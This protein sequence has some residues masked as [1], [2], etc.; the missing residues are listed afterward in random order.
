LALL[1]CSCGDNP[2]GPT[3]PTGG[4]KISCPLDLSIQAKGL[5]TTL[6]YAPPIVT[7]GTAPVSVAC[8]PSS[9]APIPVGTTKVTCIAADG[10]QRAD[11][12]TFNAVV[13]PAPMLSATR[14]VAFGDSQTEGKLGPTSYVGNPQFPDAYAAVLYDTLTKRYTAQTVDMF[15]RGL[16]GERVQ[17][18]GVARLPTVLAADAPQVLLLLEGVNDLITFGA[19]AIPTVINGLRTMVR[20]AKGRGITVFL[21]TLLPQRPGGLR[22][23][24]PTL[25]S[26]AN[27][28]IRLLAASEG[29]TLVDLYQAFGG[30]PDPWIDADGLHPNV[31][32]YQ[33][34]AATFFDAI[35]G[36]LETPAMG[37]HTALWP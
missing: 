1:A 30:S 4:P 8:T 18:D 16:G 29:V 14:F 6:T 9:G 7:G 3:N 2:T 19:S 17:P 32:G 11:S 35:R 23:G 12:C 33:K 15:D 36:R 22:A 31:A 10:Q 28:Q 5:T 21:A 25:I 20:A 24:S 13:T 26:P 34:I 27:D 37:V